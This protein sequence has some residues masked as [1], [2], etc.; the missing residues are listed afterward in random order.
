MA[1]DEKTV[2]FF[3]KLFI[4][5]LRLLLLFLLGANSQHLGWK[6]FQNEN[7]AQR[8][9]SFK[10]NFL[11]L[12]FSGPGWYIKTYNVTKQYILLQE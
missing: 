11:N 3:F 12:P 1:L 4:F 6:G 8:Q 10:D 5:A 7:G 9:G 2:V